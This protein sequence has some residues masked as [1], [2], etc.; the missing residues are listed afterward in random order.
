MSKGAKG[1]AVHLDAETVLMLEEFQRSVHAGLPD[2]AKPFY[3][4]PVCARMAIREACE[5][6]RA[7]SAA[8]GEEGNGED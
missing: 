1:K 8:Q 4:L 6:R 3:T 7:Q 2:Y 5:S